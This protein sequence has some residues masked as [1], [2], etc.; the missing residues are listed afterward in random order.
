M[1]KF[2]RSISGYNVCQ[3]NAFVDDVVERVDEM[4]NKMKQKDME[5]DRLTKE[6]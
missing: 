4:I 2:D 5:I 1:K 3:V 6:L